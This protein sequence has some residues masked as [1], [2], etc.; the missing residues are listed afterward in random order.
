MKVQELAPGLWRWTAPHPDWTPGKDWPQDVACLYY[1]APAA[2]VLVDPLVPLGDEERFWLAL[3]RDVERLA[4][5]VAVL[6][7][8][9]WHERSVD[10]VAARYG[11]S[12]WRRDTG[13]PLPAGVDAYDVPAAE[14]TVFWIPEHRA[15]V[16]GDVLETADELTLCPAGWLP[17]G[18]SLADVRRE[19]APVLE[20][21]VERV[22]VSHGAPI[23]EQA[24]VA[25]GR[26][27][28]QAPSAA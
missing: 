21:P 26:A 13:G 9:R 7:T 1:E 5:P 17:E 11:A 4:C 20:L 6:L 23:L 25:L 24:R 28:G 3:D 19:L 10:E 8:V 16:A 2:T 15:L 14:E 18:S 27:L 12:L 22:L